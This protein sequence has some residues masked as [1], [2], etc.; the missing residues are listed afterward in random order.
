MRNR[1]GI[2]HSRIHSKM[3]VDADVCSML[4]ILGL[5]VK[6]N[7]PVDPTDLSLYKCETAA[8][9]WAKLIRRPYRCNSTMG[10]LHRSQAFCITSSEGNGRHA[11][12]SGQALVVAPD[13]T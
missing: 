10:F 6:P 12:N 9:N 1:H 7:C 4:A 2:P 3:M 11:V 5:L 13:S 8:L